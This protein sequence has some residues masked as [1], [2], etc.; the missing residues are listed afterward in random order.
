MEGRSSHRD[1]G[2][3]ASG[4]LVHRNTVLAR[5]WFARCG[6]IIVNFVIVSY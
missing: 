5:V 6:A 2:A 4:R 3:P 1:Y